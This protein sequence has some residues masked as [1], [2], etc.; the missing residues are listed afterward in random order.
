MFGRKRTAQSGG[1][2]LLIGYE[3]HVARL[4]QVTLERQGY[5]LRI[6]DTVD[7]AEDQVQEQVPSFIVATTRGL[8]LTERE[9]AE[10]LLEA[11]PGC[12]SSHLLVL[13][14]SDQIS[15]DYPDDGFGPTAVANAANCGREL[16]EI[17]R[18]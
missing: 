14:P 6:A 9:I 11:N 15:G 7:E 4:L 8:G 10:R 12:R 13:N 18:S 16:D 1:V 17:S 3:Q 5:S 2:A